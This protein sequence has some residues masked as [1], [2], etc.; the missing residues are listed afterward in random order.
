MV[1]DQTYR[2]FLLAQA[3]Q[4]KRD[5]DAK[6][7]Q[8]NSQN[9]VMQNKAAADA[10]GQHDIALEQ[11]AHKN[12]MELQQSELEAKTTMKAMEGN[13][14]LEGKI[15]DSILSNPE[16]KLSDIPEF[17]W[18]KLGIT[19]ANTQQL[20]LSS[21]QKQAQIQ[22]QQAMAQQQ[23]QQQQRQQQGQGQPQQQVAA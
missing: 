4:E 9:N 2:A 5:A 13:T 3:V 10:K 19:D 16:A 12:K 15:I 23:A 11:L 22:Q 17:I 20:I 18:K 1:E 21:M 6:I 14:A 7:A 8:Q